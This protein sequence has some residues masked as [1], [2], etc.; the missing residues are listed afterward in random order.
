[1]TS[2]SDNKI[3][4]R[5][6]DIPRLNNDGSNFQGWKCR[7]GMVLDLRGL[8]KY[9]NGDEAQPSVPAAGADTTKYDLWVKNDKDAR[10]Q[11]ALTLED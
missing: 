6:L 2:N 8:T 1:M 10:A 5:L 3:S 7:I 4:N 11:I 9:V